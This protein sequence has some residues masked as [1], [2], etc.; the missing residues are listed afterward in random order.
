MI[1]LA[2]LQC[3]EQRGHDM[4][5]GKVIGVI[6]FVSA[7]SVGLLLAAGWFFSP[8]KNTTDTPEQA[9]TYKEKLT[10]MQYYVTRQKGTERAFTGEYWDNKDPGV[11]HCICCGEPLFDSDTKF[12]SGT[13]WPSFY[14]V[15]PEGT[16]ALEDDYSLLGMKRIEV[17]C[18]NC[19]AHLGH[20]FDDGPDP[21]GKR[22]CIN[23]AALD[24]EM[25]ADGKNQDADKSGDKAESGDS[26]NGDE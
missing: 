6:V 10:K 14:D 9:A 16:V 22:Y 24:F 25:E 8:K 5:R 2:E 21:T 11:Y 15:H 26:K 23:S 3:I 4:R 17:K 19:D 13:G 7:V 20:V 1:E 12:E 18:K